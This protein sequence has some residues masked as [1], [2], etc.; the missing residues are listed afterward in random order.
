MIKA[1]QLVMEYYAYTQKK[2]RTFTITQYII[3]NIQ[4]KLY[5]FIVLHKD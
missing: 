3:Y 5:A 2:F 1:F 4:I